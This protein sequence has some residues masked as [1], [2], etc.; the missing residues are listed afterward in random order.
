MFDKVKTHVKDNIDLYVVFSAGVGVAGITYL[1]MRGAASLPIRDAIGVPAQG[2]IGVLGERA[3]S[4]NIVSG[5]NNVLHSVSY[6]SADRQGPPSWVVR[7]LETGNIFT[8]QKSAAAE[9]GL[10]AAHLS[11]HLNGIREHVSGNTFER[12]CL[13]A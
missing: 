11:E 1:I 7:C 12:I 2:A 5:K 9:M 13:A 4:Q 10:S 3:V 8:S 6:F